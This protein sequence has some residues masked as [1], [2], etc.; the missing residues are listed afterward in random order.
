MLYSTCTFDERENE[1]II[2]HLLGTYPEFQILPIEP[3]EGFASGRKECVQGDAQG[4]QDTVRIFPHRMKGEGHYLALLRKGD[5]KAEEERRTEAERR[6][7]LQTQRKKARL[8]EDFQEFWQHVTRPLHEERIEIRGDKL[9]EMPEGLPD[10]RG[11]RF[12]RTGLLLGELKKNRFEPSQALAMNL[13]KED[14]DACIDLPA[15][16]ERVLRYLKGETLEVEDLIGEKAKGWYLVC[17]DG[18]PLGFGKAGRGTLKK[19]I[20]SGD[21][22]VMG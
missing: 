10:I 6:R 8:P 14:Y 2:A 16:D 5:E 4:I 3:Y 18:F 9:Y 12:L 7:P 15:E 17:V 19:L 11:L 1:Q 20:S 13:K 22:G 21:G